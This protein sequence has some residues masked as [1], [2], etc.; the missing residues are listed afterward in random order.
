M[1]WVF[2][3]SWLAEHRR[4]LF[5]WLGFR[6]LSAAKNDYH[7]TLFVVLH[8]MMVT[9]NRLK[10]LGCDWTPLFVLKF[11]FFVSLGDPHDIDGTTQLLLVVSNS[12]EHINTLLQN[13]LFFNT[14]IHR[15]KV[16]ELYVLT[17]ICDY[18]HFVA[19]TC[20]GEGRRLFTS[21]LL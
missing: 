7:I 1:F 17:I 18:A 16:T 19:M 6:N 20:F 14:V 10:T 3:L 9:S 21:T 13:K 2:V 15:T 12:S 8:A 5:F 4:L 11:L